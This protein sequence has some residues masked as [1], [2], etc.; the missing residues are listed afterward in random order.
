MS[1]WRRCRCSTVRAKPSP[2]IVSSLQP[3]NLRLRRAIR[4]REAAS[5]HPLFPALFDPQTAG[6]LLA[7]VPEQEAAACLA[8]LRAAGYERAAVIGAVTPLS[9]ALEPVVLDLFDGRPASPA[10]LADSDKVAL[11][12]R[13]RHPAEAMSALVDFRV[14]RLVCA[15]S[16]AQLVRSLI[17]RT[18]RV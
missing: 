10:P 8:D 2:G 3:Q 11:Q 17:E 13:L 1:G 18:E 7:A 9:D 12:D 4:N 15:L 14:W 5:E 16:R 6:G